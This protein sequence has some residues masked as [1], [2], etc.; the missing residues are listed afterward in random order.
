MVDRVLEPE[1]M[2]SPEEARAYDAMDFAAVNAAFC[3]DLVRALGDTSST[4]HVLDVGTGTARIPV[5]LC[6][7]LPKITV[8]GIDLAGHMLDLGA[9]HVR[10]SHLASRLRLEREDAKKLRY[11]A[12]SFDAVVSNTIV[13]HIPEPT[14]VLREMWRVLRPGGLL[15]VRDLARPDAEAS[16]DALVAQ[17]TEPVTDGDNRDERL[18]QRTLFADSLRAAL[19][20]TE[21]LACAEHAGIVPA[22]VSM[23]SDRHWTL[24]ARKPV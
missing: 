8:V 4:A 22:H 2:D 12:A 14:E 23:T 7:Q 17:Y 18:R 21:A 24:T 13:H 10:R 15:F 16:L 3:A 20:P 11:A 19:T 1:V 5:I 9:A 6:N